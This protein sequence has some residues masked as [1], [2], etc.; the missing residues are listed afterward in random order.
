MKEFGF[1][2]YWKVPACDT[3]RVGG[4]DRDLGRRPRSDKRTRDQEGVG[5]A[6]E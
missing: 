1:G 5:G 2:F 3:D 4:G 6:T